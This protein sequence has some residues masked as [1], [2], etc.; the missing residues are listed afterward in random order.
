MEK[1]KGSLISF[2]SRMV[3]EGGGI[4][5]AQ[6]KP[7]FAPPPE[8]L[9]ILKEKI[10]DLPLHQYAPGTGNFELLDL[11]V[12]EYAGY[13]SIDTDNLL[14]LQGATEGIFLAF[15]YLTTIL[16]PPYTVLSF[17][18]VYESYPKLPA[19]FRIPFVYFPL[20]PDLTVDFARL[21][22]A[23]VEKR[24]KILFLASPGNPLGKVWTREE[25][26][27]LAAL[28]D[29]Y[30]FYIIFDAVYKDIYFDLP[31]FNP[32]TQQHGKL[33]YIDSFSKMLSI[34][35]WRIGY[36]ITA[37]EHMD[38]IRAIHDYTGL[39]GPSILQA[40][41]AGY[42]KEHHFGRDYAVSVRERCR[43]SIDF[44]TRVVQGLGFKVPPIQGGYFLWA[45]LPRQFPDGF[46]FCLD[47]YEKVKLGM[48]P[49]EN[50]SPSRVSYVRMNIAMEMEIIR[51]AAV[52]LEDFFSQPRNP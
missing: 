6:G 29:K 33:F 11:L 10:D 28:S 13:A 39:S 21:E 4:N 27:R 30:D 44:M 52:R 38:R 40:A 8:L 19:L 17:E 14:V 47:L 3:A 35:G 15:L 20:G 31:P 7:G 16:K 46:R 2:F 5:L 22:R 12:R 23:I 18:P 45:A 51:Q 43:E 41:V 37:K 48:V 36:M 9:Q 26:K 49:G 50:F 1:P 34:T 25:M 42:L 24:V 32:L